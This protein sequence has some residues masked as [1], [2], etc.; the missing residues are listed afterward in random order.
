MNNASISSHKPSNRDLDSIFMAFEKW[1][2]NRPEFDTAVLRKRKCWPITAKH[3]KKFTIKKRNGSNRELVVVDK[4]LKELQSNLAAY[5]GQNYEVSDYAYGFV[6]KEPERRIGV[7]EQS[8]LLVEKLRPKGVI[9]NA[10]SHTNKKLVISMDLKDFFPTITFPRVMGLL[11]SQPYNFTNKQASILASMVCLPKDVDDKRGLP[12]GAPTSPMIS[13]LICK[14][15]DFQLGKMAKKYDV[16]YTRY[17]DDLTFSTNNLKRVSANKIVHEATKCVERNGFRVNVDKT[18]AM[19]SNQRQ[20]VTGI[21]V[22]EGLNLPKKHVDAI[23]ATLNNLE[24]KYKSV[25]EAVVGFGKIGKKN[26]YDSFVPLGYYIGG[27]KGRYIKAVNKGFKGNKPTS[28]KEFNKVYALHLL[29]RILWYGQVVT[30]SICEPY[31][32]TKRKYISPKQHSRI[33]KFEEM[34]ASYYRISMKY[35]WPVE[36]IIL[37]LANKLPH[38]QSLVKMNPSFLLDSILLNV[39]E[40]ELREKFL[41]LGLKKEE[42]TEFFESAPSSLQRILIVENRSHTNF[43]HNTIKKCIEHGWQVPSKQQLLFQDLNTGDLADLFHKSSDKQGHNVEKLLTNL[44]RVTRPQLR[45]LSPNIKAKIVAVH[46]ELLD[47]VRTEGGDVCIDLENE[48]KKTELSLQAIRDLKSAIRLYDNDTDN[49]YQKVVL[50]AVNRSGA[51]NI[52]SIDKDSM[53]S[54]IV[55]DIKAW[56]DALTK[57]LMSIVQHTENLNSTASQKAYTI[58]FRDK[59]PVT[60]EPRAIEIYRLNHNLPFKKELDIDKSKSKGRV[61]KWL[62]GGDLSSAV[63]SFLSIGDIFVHGKFLDCDDFTV[64]LTEHVYV[65]EKHEEIDKLGKLFISL[66]E[67]ND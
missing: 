62:T 53:A 32:L 24:H 23:R 3:Y 44:V 45:Y 48:T 49:F 9:T 52:F 42:Y 14:K 20:M 16:S 17:A 11:K 5:F 37:R 56:Q 2:K 8:E 18:K 4:N 36:H 51:V 54:R 30:T 59:N 10:L 67:V 33:I 29:G 43:S 66:K 6:P 1:L 28:D 38:L 13:N 41:K 65:K 12:Q 21:L 55:T 64:N 60:G 7:K 19:Y 40:N 15:L 47:L 25:D 27:Y 39:D 46:K 61:I 57:V 22:N 26:S 63:K 35:H 58:K 31:A 34:L 50:H